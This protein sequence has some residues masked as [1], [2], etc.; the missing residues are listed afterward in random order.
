[1]N[2]LTNLTNHCYENLEKME[3]LINVLQEKY[4]HKKDI[5]VISDMISENIKETTETILDIQNEIL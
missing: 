1:M 4:S 3:I 2:K 5:V